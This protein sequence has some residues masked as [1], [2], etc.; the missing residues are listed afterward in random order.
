MIYKHWKKFVLAIASLFWFGCG[1]DSS[2]SDEKTA[3]SFEGG[4]CPEYGVHGYLCENPEDFNSPDID[5]KCTFIPRDPCTDYYKCEDGASCYK[6]ENE[7][8]MS[9][10]DAQGNPIPQDEIES[11]YYEK[12]DTH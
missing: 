7:T 6:Q 12:E 4:V 3:C 10:Y 8:V 1:D 5:E 11:R 2:S 9:C